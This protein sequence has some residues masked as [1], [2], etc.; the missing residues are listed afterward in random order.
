MSEKGEIVQSVKQLTENELNDFSFKQ[1]EK[2]LKHTPDV[3]NAVSNMGEVGSKSQ[4]NVYS[5]IDKAIDV[6]SEQLKDDNLTEET[7]DKLNDRIERM[8]DKSFQKDSEFKRWMGAS[9][10]AGVSGAALA[11]A[12]NPEARKTLINLLTKKG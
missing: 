1:D 4:D 9:I 3:I 7:R 6:F 11:L 2:L 10:V 8:V 12:K 5:T